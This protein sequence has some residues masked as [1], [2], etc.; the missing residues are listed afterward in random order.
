MSQFDETT[1]AK[2]KEL[3]VLP[4]ELAEPR[5]FGFTKG[6]DSAKPSLEILARALQEINTQPC[7]EL[8]LNMKSWVF[9]AKREADKAIA[10]VKTRGDWPLEEK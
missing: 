7:D 5:A 9:S 6:R 2:A 3:Y 8:F 4:E 10:E 1:K